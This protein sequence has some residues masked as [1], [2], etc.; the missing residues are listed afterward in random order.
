[1]AGKERRVRK[2]QDRGL[3]LDE[4]F[5]PAEKSP[6]WKEAY[7]IAGVEVQLAMEMAWARERIGMTQAAL[8]K[9]LGTTQSAVAR[10]E[11]AGQ[12]VTLKTLTKIAE[13]LGAELVVTMRPRKGQ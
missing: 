8:A 13:A 6:E 3:T 10:I 9:V 5:G 4:C 7:A 1:M 12:N 11:G 2:N